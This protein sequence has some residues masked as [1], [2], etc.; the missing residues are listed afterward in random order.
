MK[1][2]DTLDRSHR[3]PR[4]LLAL[5]VMGT[6]FANPV[7]A[8]SVAYIPNA[9]GKV[10]VID[11]VTDRVI[12][13][14]HTL[15]DGTMP[16]GVGVLSGVPNL[17]ISHTSSAAGDSDLL[18]LISQGKPHALST[19]QVGEGAYGVAVDPDRTRLYVANS[20]S[21]SISVF[22]TAG[23][24]IATLDLHLSRPMGLVAA[25]RNGQ[26][27]LYVTESE[28]KRIAVVDPVYGRVLARIPVGEAPVGIAIDAAGQRLFVGNQGDRSLSAIDIA[29]AQTVATLPLGGRPYGIAVSPDGK[30]VYTANHR[31]NARRKS[32]RGTVS[33]IDAATLAEKGRVTVG[34]RPVGLSVTPDGRKLYVVNHDSN[35]VSVISIRSTVPKRIKTLAAGRGP[36]AFGSF[37]GDDGQAPKL[38]NDLSSAIVSWVFDAFEGW[39]ESQFYQAIGQQAPGPATQE[40]MNEVI[41]DLKNIQTA[42][43]NIADQ[44]SQLY[45][46]FN[47][48]VSLITDDAYSNQKQFLNQISA[49]TV[50]DFDQFS[51]DVGTSTLSEVAANSGILGKLQQL[52]TDAYLAQLATSSAEISDTS[53]AGAV[54]ILLT[55]ANQ[56][57]IAN[58]AKTIGSK[59]DI[60]N[61]GSWTPP[62]QTQAQ[63]LSLFDQYNNGL[64]GQYIGLVTTLQQIYTIEQTALYLQY[65]VPDQFGNLSMAEPGLVSTNT[66]AQNSALLQQIY[67]QRFADL[68]AMFAKAF[69]SDQGGQSPN[70]PIPAN[71][72]SKMPGE[73]AG[74]WGSDGP[75]S[76]F[77]WQG[78]MPQ[79]QSGYSGSWNGDA[80]TAQCAPGKDPFN[81]KTITLSQMCSSPPGNVSYFAWPWLNN[82]GQL[83]CANLNPA[84]Y[85][86]PAWSDTYSYGYTIAANWSIFQTH[87]YLG[88]TTSNFG[89]Q[90]GLPSL[91]PL[92][93]PLSTGSNW[94]GLGLDL[95]NV[96]GGSFSALLQYHGT[97]GLITAISVLENTTQSGRSQLAEIA[98]GCAIG[99]GDTFCAQLSETI[100]N[101]L[102]AGNS[103]ICIGGDQL[104][105]QYQSFG[106]V[107]IVYNGSCTY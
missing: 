32:L 91:Q 97:T 47:D 30:T 7:Q 2:E 49:G 104:T 79:G 54:P 18:A 25:N 19:L 41:D 45:G 50:A 43:T 34:K 35:A 85:S 78:L 102:G 9:A 68:K 26:R 13:R 22:S 93:G 21:G 69:V 70:L 65:A 94:N 3:P 80:L 51:N 72:A 53:N 103:S 40:Q 16:W 6:I 106:T 95:G 100:G 76:L 14:F 84:A 58:I 92:S 81:P 86:V 107:T 59:Q 98:I 61:I 66:F 77:T 63:R 89:T 23:Q 87:Q 56:S 105:M 96:P 38:G 10:T 74:T 46:L 37:I 15:H 31:E 39:A 42:L 99:P 82:E 29:S 27:R 75:C 48:L 101:T 4:R 33:V 90:N 44:L 1:T 11:T 71:N 55:Y 5:A 83:Q 12:K 88:I 24:L 62:G 20:A 17:F 64:L 28:G 67:T 60:M 8:R 36:A 73:P 57:L 52:I